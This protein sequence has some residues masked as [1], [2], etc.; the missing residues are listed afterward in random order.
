ML[1]VSTIGDRHLLNTIDTR[2]FLS[3]PS[4]SS[5][6]MRYLRSRDDNHVTNLPFESQSTRLAEVFCFGSVCGLLEEVAS[7]CNLQL[8]QPRFKPLPGVAAG[9]SYSKLAGSVEL[10]ESSHRTTCY[11][12][13][14]RSMF[15]TAMTSMGLLRDH[16]THFK[17]AEGTTI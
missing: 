7:F 17:L 13:R 6:I 8:P 5:L 4:H 15:D 1:S 3:L 2:S 12:R 11:S 10:K 9:L 14:R 16:S